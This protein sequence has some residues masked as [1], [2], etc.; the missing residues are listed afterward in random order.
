MARPNFSWDVVPLLQLWREKHDDSGT[1]GT[2]LES[3]EPRE[4]ISLINE[5]LAKNTVSHEYQLDCTCTMQ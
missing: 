2:L 5:A 1:P 4:A 3:Y